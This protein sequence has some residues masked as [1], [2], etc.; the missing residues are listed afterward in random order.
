LFVSL[1]IA[2]F[3]LLPALYQG[4]SAFMS[5]A[6]FV[7]V[8]ALVAKGQ[9]NLTGLHPEWQLRLYNS[10]GEPYFISS[11]TTIN[12]RIIDANRRRRSRASSLLS[13]RRESRLHHLTAGQVPNLSLRRP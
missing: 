1:G 8:L 11:R 12:G 6:L 9:Q 2:I 10:F 5:A 13:G 7:G 3:E 4:A